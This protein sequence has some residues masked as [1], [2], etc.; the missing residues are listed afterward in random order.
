MQMPDDI[1]SW[2]LGEHSEDPGV[3]WALGLEAGREAGEQVLMAL[4]L[5]LRPGLL[6]LALS[7]WGSGGG[8]GLR[9]AGPAWPGGWEGGEAPS[10][11]WF[12]E[13]DLQRQRLQPLRVC[14][15][16]ARWALAPLLLIGG[17][18]SP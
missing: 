14:A 1:M 13:A 4:K 15:P 18:G 7:A 2:T 9:E 17:L 8:R 12:G 6:L 16:L 3:A 10:P 5:R 11:G